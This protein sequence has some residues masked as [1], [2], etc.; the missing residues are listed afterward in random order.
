[1]KGTITIS[2]GEYGGFYVVNQYCFRVCL[3]WI[4]FTYWPFD[5]DNKLEEMVEGE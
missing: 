4:A 5:I 1:M 3:G 2:V